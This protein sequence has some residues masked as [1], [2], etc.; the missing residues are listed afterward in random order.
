MIIS[1]WTRR[2]VSLNNAILN[3]EEIAVSIPLLSINKRVIRPIVESRRIDSDS[4]LVVS[5]I[6]HCV[7]LKIEIGLRF[8]DTIP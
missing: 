7:R 4:V 1:S 5:M 6:Y 8:L 3:L 2:T